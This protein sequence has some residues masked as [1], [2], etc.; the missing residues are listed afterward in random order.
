VAKRSGLLSA[1]LLAVALTGFVLASQWGHAAEP[2]AYPVRASSES[3]QLLRDE[4][5]LIAEMIKGQLAAERERYKELRTAIN[6]PAV[7]ATSVS[8]P[9]GHAPASVRGRRN[10]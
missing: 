8:R 9:S 1:G 5:D 7:G 3:M 2:P 4:H 10:S 6:A